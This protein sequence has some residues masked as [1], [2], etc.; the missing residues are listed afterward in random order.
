MGTEK[1]GQNGNDGEGILFMKK[2]P[3]V[4]PVSRIT[5]AL[6]QVWLRSRERAAALKRDKYTCQCCGRKQTKRKGEEFIVH[7]HHRDG[8]DWGEITKIIRER[9]LQ[10]P[11][12]LV[13]LC[14]ECHE[15]EH[16]NQ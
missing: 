15:I 1:L 2:N 10:T 14:K 3:Y 5:A 16:E 4:T 12:A 6:R 7:V 13:T 11:D 8:I 9:V